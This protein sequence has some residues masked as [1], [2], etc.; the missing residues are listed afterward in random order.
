MSDLTITEL[1]EKIE[2]IK[3]DIATSD[4]LKTRLV[5]SDYLDYLKDEIRMLE[6]V[7]RARTSTDK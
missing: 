7:D 6:N 4:D 3:K 1:K 5:L 2:N